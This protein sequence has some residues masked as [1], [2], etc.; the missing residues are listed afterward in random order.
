MFIVSIAL[1]LIAGYVHGRKGYSH[2]ASKRF[3][4]MAVYLLAGYCGILMVVVSVWGMFNP[5]G[6]AGMLQTEPRSPFQDFFLIAYLGMA[7]MA[8]LSIWYRERYLI[9]NVVCWSVY[10]FGATYLHLVE[11]GEAGVLSFDLIVNVLAA[12][13][14]VPV[15]LIILVGLSLRAVPVGEKDG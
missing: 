13:T 1:L 11:Y 7:L 6:A 2:D 5:E 3:E 9:A 12:H 8:A 15:L 4:L 10:W 14:L